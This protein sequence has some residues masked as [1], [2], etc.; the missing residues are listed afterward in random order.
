MEE[1]TYNLIK[2]CEPAVAQLDEFCTAHGLAGLVKADLVSIKC[3]SKEVY[4]SRRA[5]YDADSRFIYQAPI[6]GR[7]IA[8]VGL[9]E[10]VPT[11]VGDIRIL[12]IADQKPDNSQTDRMDHIGIAPVGI[13]YDDLVGKLRENGAVLEEIVRPHGYAACDVILPTGFH[14]RIQKETLLDRVKREEM[15]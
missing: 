4:E 15:I 6:A 11:S 3:S 8:I 2:I 12:E 9:R 14:L 5:Y 7:R 10:A 1:K 13:S